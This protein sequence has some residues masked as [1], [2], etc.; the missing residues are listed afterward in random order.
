MYEYIPVLRTKSLYTRGI[1]YL[2]PHARDPNMA[3]S[4][5]V[6]HE[7]IDRVIGSCGAS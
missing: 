2:A 6:Y 1:I 7:V 5:V 4:C 3:D